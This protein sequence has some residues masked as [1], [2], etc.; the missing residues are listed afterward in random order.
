MKCEDA[1]QNL[2]ACLDG[3]A[4]PQVH[5]EIAGHLE[6]CAACRRM[7]R[8]L[9][10]LEAA[11]GPETIPPVPAGLHERIMAAARG[12]AEKPLIVLN[13][14]I[15]LGAMQPGWAQSIAPWT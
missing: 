4:E 7:A 11:I 2:S 5:R 14:L 15:W 8:E 6:Q 12:A 3:E 1:Q 9:E 10:A 13:P